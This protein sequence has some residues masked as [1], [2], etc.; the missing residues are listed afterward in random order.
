MVF[1]R[2]GLDVSIIEGE[3]LYIVVKASRSM[4]FK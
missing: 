4:G 3:H 2:K 1:S